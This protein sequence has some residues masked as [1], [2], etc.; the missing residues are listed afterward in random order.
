MYKIYL[1]INERRDKTYIGFTAN[2]DVRLN[3]HRSSKVKTTQNFGNFFCQILEEV[4]SL[5]EAR[6]REKYYK[7]AAGRRRLKQY[8]K[9]MALSSNG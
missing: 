8:F 7:S 5:V 6:K 3:Y 4:D 1:L 2:I 9:T